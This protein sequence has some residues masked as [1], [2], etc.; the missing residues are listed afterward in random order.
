MKSSDIRNKFQ[1]YFTSHGHQFIPS[2]SLIPKED[3]SL[4]FVNAGMN[5]LKNYFLG[6][7]PPPHSRLCSIQKCLRAGGKHNDLEQVGLSPYH[8]TFFE[9]MGY[10]SFGNYFK[11]EACFYA[12]DFLTQ[13]LGLAKKNLWI[14][15]FKN[16]TATSEIWQKNHHIPA[17]KIF[18]LDAKTNFW[19]MGDSGPCGPCSEIYYYDGPKKAPTP[20][21]MLEV[22]N[23]VF[24]EF[25]ENWQG[26]K[27]KLPKPCIDTGMGLERLTAILQGVTDNYHTQFFKIM[28]QAIANATKKKYDPQIPETSLALRIVADHARAISFLI[29]DGILPSNLGA[30]YVLRRLLRRALFYSHKL[31]PSKNL[32][33]IGADQNIQ[34][35]QSFYPEL[36]QSKALIYSTIQKEENLFMQSLELGKTMFFQKI[37]KLPDRKIPPD[38]IWDLYSTYG[39]PLDLTQLL[40]KEHNLSAPNTNLSTLKKEFDTPKKLSQHTK[41]HL[42]KNLA[43]VIRKHL[44]QKTLFTGY[45]TQQETGKIIG[46]FS[47]DT[48]SSLASLKNQQSSWMVTDKSCFYAEGGGAVGDTGYI[49]SQTGEAKVIDT[50]KQGDFIFHKVQLKTGKLQKNQTIELKVD[51]LRR[52]QIAT[53]HS[54]T[55][56]LHHT[57]RQVLGTQTK[58]MGSLVEPGKLRFDFSTPLVPNWQQLLTIESKV[59]KEIEAKHPVR[60]SIK[61]YASAIQTGVLFLEQE[62][63]KKTVRVIQIGNSQEL[64]GGIHV[65]NSMDI[66]GFKIISCTGVQSGIRRILAFT[67]NS[68]TR[69]RQEMAEQNKMLRDYLNWPILKMEEKN[70]FIQ[71]ISYKEQEIKYLKKELKN[72]LFNKESKALAPAKF[73]LDSLAKNETKQQD[74]VT[75]WLAEQNQELRMYLN[76]PLPKEPKQDKSLLSIL[77]KI[78]SESKNLKTQIQTLKNKN[79]QQF[80]TKSQDFHLQ[81][82]HGKCLTTQLPIKDSKYLIEIAQHIHTSTPEPR[83]TILLGNNPNSSTKYPIIVMVSKELQKNISANFILKKIIAPVVGAKGGG[84]EH[85]A[86]GIVT[87]LK[88]LSQLKEK[89]F[90][91][92]NTNAN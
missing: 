43:D 26:E 41:D 79:I 4:L 22:W 17:E 32:L 75:L 81:N 51:I 48:F 9:M 27:N 18:F 86:Q 77:Q 61:P 56:L 55:H 45:T 33:C 90:S 84:N 50:Q 25:N 10:F 6:I 1:K 89:L 82:I 8:H 38:L 72:I 28:I 34:L 60:A 3:T 31:N 69:W 62:S 71:W 46:I 47:I 40:A 92:L 80:I 73:K 39:F 88:Q 52:K 36:K 49:T 67:S 91:Y 66:Q 54:A 76:L 21:D 65:K 70:P 20:E 13:E 11:K 78:N 14:S 57:L 5:P 15:V 85:L 29:S 37:K 30:G 42:K 83:V 7:A 64:C 87:N 24:M 2:S 68:L 23:L 12:Y 16:D 19:R 35:M 44:T 53:S 74:A 63:Y 58:Q 59:N